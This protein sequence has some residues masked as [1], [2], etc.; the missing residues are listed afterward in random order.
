MEGEYEMLADDGRSFMAPVDRFSLS[1]PR[2][3]H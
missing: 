1:V 2:V 3:L